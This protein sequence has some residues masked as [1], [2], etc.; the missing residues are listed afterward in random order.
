MWRWSGRVEELQAQS[1][2]NI[3]LLAPTTLTAG[4][5][6]IGLGD[7][8]IAVG[9]GQIHIA[10]LKMSGAQLDTAGEISQ[11]PVAEYLALAGIKKTSAAT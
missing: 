5:D 8:R 3:K 2:L 9:A 4:A 10:R 7:T 1:L 11:V 6:V